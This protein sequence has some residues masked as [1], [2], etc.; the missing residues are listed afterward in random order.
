MRALFKLELKE[1][2]KRLV[3]A[4]ILNSRD[5]TRRPISDSNQQNVW[6]IELTAL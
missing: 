2:F 5:Q 6:Q 3:S 4:R 1:P